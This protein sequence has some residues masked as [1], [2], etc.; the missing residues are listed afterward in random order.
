MIIWM[1]TSFPFKD[2]LICFSHIISEI[3]FLIYSSAL[4]AFLSESMTT[5]SR[6]SLGTKMIWGLIALI[7]LIWIIFIIHIVKVCIFK[8]VAKKDEAL[9]KEIEKEEKENAEK[10][11]AENERAIECQERRRKAFE[12]INLQREEE[13]I[14]YIDL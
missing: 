11:R 14:I 8:R 10:I 9:A 1:I 3:G 12:I 4:F 2:K 6:S 13:V 7:I 5:S